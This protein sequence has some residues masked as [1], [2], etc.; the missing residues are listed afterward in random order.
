MKKSNVFTMFVALFLLV[1]MTMSL[2]SS[3]LADTFVVT[4]RNG[5]NVRDEL[6]DIVGVL[7]YGELVNVYRAK[8]KYMYAIVWHGG[9]HYITNEGLRLA[10]EEEV[11]QAA[12]RSQM[13][14]ARTNLLG[15]TIR[16]TPVFNSEDKI[17]GRLAEG[18]IV[19]ITRTRR[20]KYT[21]EYNGSHHFVDPD[22]VQVYDADIPGDGTLYRVTSEYEIA[23]LRES[24]TKDSKLVATLKPGWYVR[25]TE[26]VNDKWV[27]VIYDAEGHEAYL[28]LVYLQNAENDNVFRIKD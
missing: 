18:E 11:Q 20:D 21:I 24:A 17:L 14:V 16:E 2:C 25:V 27:K 15:R 22:D 23:N 1:I 3:A 4:S 7:S 10:T 8:S 9:M 26:V 13:Y 28:G 5:I 19:R 6:G 12:Q